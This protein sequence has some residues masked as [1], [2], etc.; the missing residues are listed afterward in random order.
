MI[1]N[2]LSIWKAAIRNQPLL[3]GGGPAALISAVAAD[4]WQAT[5]AS[6]TPPTFTPDSSPVSDT[7][8]RQ[9]FAYSAGAVSATTYSEA[10]V[11]TKRV[12]GAFPNLSLTADTV[13]LDDYVYSTDSRSGVTNNSTEISPKPVA[14]WVMPS[15][16]CVGNSIALEIVAFHRDARDGQQVC[17]VEFSATDGTNTVTQ[18]VSGAMVVSNKP[19]DVG[20]VQTIQCTLDISTLTAAPQLITCH[21]K[22][23][24]WLGSTATSPSSVLDSRDQS[25]QREFSARYFWRNT[26]LAAAPPVAYVS[27][28]SYTGSQGSTPVGVDATGVWSTSHATAAATPFLTIAGAMTAWNNAGRGI[29]NAT[30]QGNKLDAAVI[31]C[32]EGTFVL[33]SIGSGTATQNY[34][35]MVITRDTGVA[36]ASS[37]ISW[38]AAGYRPRLGA[39]TAPVTENAI[40]FYDISILRTGNLTLDGT[41][42]GGFVNFTF[43]NVNLNYQTFGANWQVNSYDCIFGMVATNSATTCPF[44]APSLVEHRIIRGLTA[45]LPP[46]TGIDG[47]CV[48][49]SALTTCPAHKKTNLKTMNGAIRAFNR[50]NSPFTGG[51]FNDYG[52]SFDCTGVVNV[53]NIMEYTSATS[54]TMVTVNADGATGDVSHMICHNNTCAG[55]FN[56]GRS[57]FHYED[58]A[59][60]RTSKLQSVKGNIFVQMNTK[61]DR[62][63]TD[64]ARVGNWGFLYGVG[65]QGNMTMYIDATSGGLGS[66]FAQE[67]PGLGCSYGTSSTTRNDPLFVAYAGTTNSG[68]TPIAGAGG[69]DYNLQ[70]GSPAKALVSNAVLARDYAGTAR[71][72]SGDSAGAYYRA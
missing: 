47:W 18:V 2:G 65:C 24:P 7:W 37:I 25:S 34:A 55:F 69:G 21:A 59:T 58:G 27:N 56:N 15:R 16:S 33:G 64:G 9:G 6:G 66:E 67:Y 29:N 20:A 17:A 57:N 23:Y 31:I 38:G 49:G 32:G 52:S 30:G 62:F 36:K 40:R 72:A 4:G 39:T 53:G 22:V 44:D 10:R 19:G 11:Y 8:S 50:Y 5:W 3:G 14:Q 1:G 61:G 43:H 12:R 42:S 41:G 68:S 48:L 45:T 51:G 71:P 28:T 54:G 35:E 13:A 26:A 60:A 46:A 63:V 70:S